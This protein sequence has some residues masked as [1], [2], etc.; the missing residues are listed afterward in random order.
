MSDTPTSKPARAIYDGTA[1]TYDEIVTSATRGL[2]RQWKEALLSQL[3]N[4]R[5]VLDLACGTG[6]L[7]FM[8]RD[9]YPGAQVVGVDVSAAH[10]DVAI[11]RACLRRD[12]GVRFLLGSAEDV[13]PVGHF[14]VIASCY[15][16]KYAELP[17][18]IAR[19]GRL[20]E[21]GGTVIMHDFTYPEHPVVRKAWERHFERLLVGARTDWPEA[22]RMFEL[23]P[24]VIRESSWVDNLAILL[25][26]HGF[27]GI[28]VDTLSRGCAAIVRGTW[29]GLGIR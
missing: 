19:L 2:D 12:E 24:R 23:L 4:P 1:E 11:G 10:L 13:N 16:S 29:P 17:R 6:M 9:R 8:I 27:D 26:A 15:L 7:T 14:D 5:R 3:D 22:Q 20:L 21:P 18:L 25:G 28:Q